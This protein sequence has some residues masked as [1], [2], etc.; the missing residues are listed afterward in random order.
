[1]SRATRSFAWASAPNRISNFAL[2]T[3]SGSGSAST[4]R[5]ARNGN[6]PMRP[7]QPD[8][9]LH[10]IPIEYNAL[11]KE[12]VNYWKIIDPPGTK[13]DVVSDFPRLESTTNY[14]ENCAVCHTSQ[15]RAPLKTD[16]PTQHAEF[17]EPGIDCEMCHGPS[18][19]HVKQMRSGRPIKAD[20]LEPPVDFRKIDNRNGVRVCAQCHRQSAIREMGE[21]G[22]M[23]YSTRTALSGADFRPPL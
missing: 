12:W 6:K 16:S 20:L 10:V 18:L 3:G 11:S 19:W 21:A 4:T 5:S 14:Q 9:T 7:K 17:R 22:E 15:L 2:R 8:G 13:R 1:M 23:N